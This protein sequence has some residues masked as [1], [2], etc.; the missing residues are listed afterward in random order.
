MSNCI[1][2]QTIR[3]LCTST[4]PSQAK[5]LD[6]NST[7]RTGT[8]QNPELSRRSGGT[9]I[10]AWQVVS[11][12]LQPR[13]NWDFDWYRQSPTQSISDAVRGHVGVD[14][15]LYRLRKGG[16]TFPNLELKVRKCPLCELTSQIK[17]PKF[18]T[19]ALYPFQVICADHF[20]KTKKDTSTYW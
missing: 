5:L 15:T 9:P 3:I 1:W 8:S 13:R 11:T 18:T 20:R 12:G 2:K 4:A 16:Y 7:F 17:A 10:G 6:G 14:I 19:A